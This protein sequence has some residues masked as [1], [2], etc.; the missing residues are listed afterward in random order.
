[1][2]V[3]RL[4]AVLV[5][6]NPSATPAEV[7]HVV[8]DCTPSIVLT[9]APEAGRFPP[10]VAVLGLD[11]LVAAADRPPGSRRPDPVLNPAAD[12]LIV[13]TSGTTGTPKGAV[14]THASLLAGVGRRRLGLGGRRPP[15][16]HL[17]PLP[18]PRVVRRAVRH[19]GRRRVGHRVRPLRRGRRPDAAEDGANTMFFGV[20]TMYHRLAATRRSGGLARLRLCVSGSAPLAADLWTRS[21]PRACPCS[22]ATA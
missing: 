19:V 10:S 6:V 5:T 12:A 20:P 14:H 11:D 3:L 21:T 7:A 8:G 4:G 15:H 16:P 22:N 17:A 9:D 13:Y 18:R 2:A 1:M